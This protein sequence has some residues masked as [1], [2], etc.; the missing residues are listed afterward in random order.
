MEDKNRITTFV[1]FWDLKGGMGLGKGD[2][3]SLPR[4]EGLGEQVD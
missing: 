3:R 1:L 4:K 2:D